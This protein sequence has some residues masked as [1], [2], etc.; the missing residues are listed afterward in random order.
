MKVLV[1]ER[2]TGRFV[3]GEAVFA[4]NASATDNS[5]VAVGDSLFVENNYG[6]TGPT[7]TLFGSTTSPQFS[8]RVGSRPSRSSSAI[9]ALT[10]L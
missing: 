6:Y 1:Y 7:S 3:C 2:A 5:L 10:T 8:G 4:D 9:S